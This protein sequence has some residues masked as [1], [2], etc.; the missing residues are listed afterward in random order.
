MSLDHWTI[1]WSYQLIRWPRNLNSS[2]V[3]SPISSNSS[4]FEIFDLLSIWATLNPTCFVFLS[5]VHRNVLDSNFDR[6][7]INKKEVLTLCLSAPNTKY[8]LRHYHVLSLHEYPWFVCQI[9]SLVTKKTK[10]PQLTNLLSLALRNQVTHIQ[11]CSSINETHG[12]SM[13]LVYHFA[14]TMNC[15]PMRLFVVGQPQTMRR[16]C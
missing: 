3:W 4:F 5:C 1:W 8:A 9:Q 6:P 10:W 12:A 14:T 2:F 13:Y 15:A 16:W 7:K 11:L